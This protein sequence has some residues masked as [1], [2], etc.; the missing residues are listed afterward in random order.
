[1]AA[2]RGRSRPTSS[3]SLAAIR[4]TEACPVPTLLLEVDSETIVAASPSAVDLLSNDSSDVV[5]RNPEDFT[6]DSPSGG[7]PLLRAGRIS[8]YQTTRQVRVG[9]Q[10]VPYDMWVRPA[11]QGPEV[12]LAFAVIL[13]PARPQYLPPRAPPGGEGGAVVVGSTDRGLVIDRMSSEVERLLGVG[14]DDLLG[15]SLLSLVD[16]PDAADLLS[17]LAQ[18]VAT[19]TGGMIRIGFQT[20][21][22]GPVSTL[23]ALWPLVPP[24][25]IAFALVS[26]PSIDLSTS[27]RLDLEDLLQRFVDAAGLL[28]MSRNLD[29]VRRDIPGV[30]GLST[31][32][33]QI[34]ERLLAG[35]RVP[36]IARDLYLSPSTVRNHLSSVFRE[37][38]VSSQQQLLDLL[39]KK[40][41]PPSYP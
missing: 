1:V 39:R 41:R 15:K 25:S 36:A 38:G 22:G 13:K 34:V 26:D 29:D 20:R 2:S 19:G 21:S 18:T 40:D 17:A 27:A 16:A 4:V 6:E 37:L 14:A 9:G 3:R 8:G 33:L 35:D 32:E 11:D 7:L 31:R 10:R 30:S 12:R 24:P 5:G 23:L 28:S